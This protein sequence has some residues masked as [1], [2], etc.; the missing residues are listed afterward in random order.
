MNSITHRRK[1]Y[2][3]LLE[4]SYPGLST[5]GPPHYNTIHSWRLISIVQLEYQIGAQ[6]RKVRFT[7]HSLSWVSGRCVRSAWLRGIHWLRCDCIVE[8][9]RRLSAGTLYGRYE[10][11][12]WL[13]KLAWLT[14]QL[15][16]FTL[17]CLSRRLHNISFN[18]VSIQRK[19]ST[20]KT[21]AGTLSA[22][23][24]DN[25]ARRK[26]GARFHVTNSLNA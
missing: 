4:G 17:L 6:S 24:R 3:Q 19:I 10:G 12:V 11:V 26:N 9:A 20:R 25:Y 1:L 15:C 18:A 21:P 22:F 14:L 8:P 23:A 16:C 7:S 2:G 5:Y 13:R